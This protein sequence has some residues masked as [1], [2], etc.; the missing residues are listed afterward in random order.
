MAHLDT[1]F[2]RE[3]TVSHGG[4][5]GHQSSGLLFLVMSAAVGAA[6]LMLP[7]AGLAVLSSFL[8]LTGFGLAIAAWRRSAEPQTEGIAT[9]DLAAL[10]V[11]LG[12][13]AALLG[14][15]ESLLH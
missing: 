13:L 14:D 6:C 5:G 2:G 11:F 7:A 4:A 12:F 10:L 3:P 1:T 8:L 15:T 9:K